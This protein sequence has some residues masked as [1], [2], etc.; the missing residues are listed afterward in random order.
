MEFVRTVIPDKTEK[1]LRHHHLGFW[2]FVHLTVAAVTI[3]S[4][5]IYLVFLEFSRLLCLKSSKGISKFRLPCM[6]NGFYLKDR[7]FK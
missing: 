6:K 1:V 5:Q 2:Y 7:T 4:P 3:T